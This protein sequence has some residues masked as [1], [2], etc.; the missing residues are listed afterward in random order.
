ME[1]FEHLGFLLHFGDKGSEVVTLSQAAPFFANSDPDMPAIP[2]PATQVHD[3]I[4][5]NISS[6]LEHITERISAKENGPANSS[7]SDVAMTDA[8]T[9]SI[10]TPPSARGSFFIEGISKSSFVKQ[11]SDL[12]GSSSVKVSIVMNIIVP[13]LFLHK[14]NQIAFL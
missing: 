11:P 10:K 1:G 7:D 3:W 13:S 5:Q 2:A 4:S 6:A 8:C 9:S 12:K 14:N